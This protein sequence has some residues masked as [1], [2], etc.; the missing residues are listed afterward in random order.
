MASDRLDVVTLGRVSV[1]LYGQQIGGRLEDMASFAKYVGGSPANVAIGAARL[2]LRAALISRVGDE[3]LGRF[4]REELVR[5]GVDVRGLA[6]DPQRLTA[7]VVLGVRDR[8]TFPLIFYRENCADM[9]LGP[10]DVDEGLVA[11]AAAVVLTGTHLS[12][13]GVAAASRRAA[14]LARRHGARVVLDIDYRPVLWGLAGHGQ[15][16]SRFAPGAGVTA[17]LQALLPECDVVVG[18]EEE[19]H[20]A[21]GSQDTVEAL[22]RV[23]AAGRAL[24]V[25]KRG[26]AG[27]VAFP[28]EIPARP[29]EGLAVPGHPVEVYN[30]LGAGDAFLAGFLR[31]SLRG[32]PLERALVLANACGA[33]VAARHGCAPATPG[34]PE[35][36][37]FLARGGRVARPRLDPELSH[38][39]W[40]TA[41]RPAPAELAVVVLDGGPE[42]LGPAEAHGRP[43]AAIAAFQRLVYDAVARA[44]EPGS[45]EPAFGAILD[46]GSGRDTLDL[47]SGGGHWIARPIEGPD[48]APLAFRGGADVGVTLREWPVPQVVRCRLAA[49]PEEGEAGAGE[50]ERGLLQLFEACR[51]TGHELLVEL[52]P[53]RRRP[54]DGRAAAALLARLCAAGVR[55]DW[56]G[57][58]A[59]EEPGGWGALEA[60][61]AAG[62]PLCR[63]ALLLDPGGP[64]AELE[65]AIET[66]A[67]HA[68]CRGFAVGPGLFGAAARGWFAGRLSDAQARAEV[69][70]RYARLVDLWRRARRREP[71]AAARPA[72]LRDAALGEAG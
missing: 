2:G 22:R 48:A 59:P 35:L 43:P 37:R 14:E 34:W 27:C 18:T 49:P 41:R 45:G 29:E 12:R 11:E 61:L 15:G 42:L 72:A 21:G 8:D 69:A 28:G 6:T 60:A 33:L 51:A 68:L 9:A 40:A 55:P 7:L 23:R 58:A 20:I 1:D 36:E 32:E 64:E 47:A 39:H 46:D 53:G 65:A 13:P 38:L 4:V 3:A 50:L 25:L 10:E 26:A 67:R 57:I 70:D 5:E 16:A 52:L 24:L 17:Q 63:G 31:G 56:W 44:A 54:G 30:V 19:I 62:D 66:G 71:G